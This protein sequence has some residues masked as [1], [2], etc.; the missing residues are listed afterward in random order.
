MELRRQGGAILAVVGA[1][2]GLAGAYEAS[3]AAMYSSGNL[4]YVSMLFGGVLASGLLAVAVAI[5]RR[6]PN[7]ALALV[8]GSLV[9]QMIFRCGFL[10]VHAAVIV[11]MYFAARTGDRSTMWAAL[12]SVPAGPLMS[13]LFVISNGRHPLSVVG[14]LFPHPTAVFAAAAALILGSSWL[15]GLAA[16]RQQEAGLSSAAL[17]VAEE[18]RSLAQQE[19]EQAQEIARLMEARTALARD[20]HDVVGHSLAVILAQAESVAYLPDS[21]RDG[22]KTAVANIAAAARNSLQEVREVLGTAEGE[23]A[24]ADRLDLWSL[25]ESVRSSGREV[26]VEE[27]GI[28]VE[29]DA[30]ATMVRYRATQELLTNAL[31]HGSANAVI[32]LTHTWGDDLTI[33]VSNAVDAAQ[34]WNSEGRGLEG[35]RQRLARVRGTLEIKRTDSGCDRVFLARCVVPLPKESA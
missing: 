6:V 4:Q 15:L 2:V 3:L 19:R 14:G 11:V 1:V 31:R 13:A 35:M 21:D 24:P 5:S 20:V 26:V 33:E 25:V 9:A 23:N 30:A 7:A 12:I 34:V 22:V 18:E 28:P 16:R 10:W 27:R 17:V 29:L 32:S 8:W